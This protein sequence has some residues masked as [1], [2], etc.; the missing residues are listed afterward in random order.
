MEPLMQDHSK[1]NQ[2]R[3]PTTNSARR[4]RVATTTALLLM[5]ALHASSDA[6]AQ[7]K[8]ESAEQAAN[9]LMGA[10]GNNDPTNMLAILGPQYEKQLVTPD[11]DAEAEMRQKIA[12]AAEKKQVLQPISDDT[13]EV[14]IGAEEWPLPIPLIR[15]DEGTWSFETEEGIEVIIDRRIGRNEKSAVAVM[16]AYVDAQIEYAQVDRNGDDYFEYAQRLASS[17]GQQDGLYW[18]A[19]E[20]SD[21]SPFGP[22]VQGAERYLGTVAAGDP[23]R[24]Y[25]FKV[26]T[27]QGANAPGGEQS[28]VI[29]GRMVL[30]FALVA[31]PADFG[32]SGVMTFV[33]NHRGIVQ[34]KDIGAFDG[35]DTYD[36][37]DTWLEVEAGS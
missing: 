33:V 29:D 19:S 1:S 12:V 35:M 36:P 28:Y 31:F 5:A 7:Q 16:N 27:R 32:N 17:P 6:A 9:A 13:I 21:E 22:L 34:Q 30:G 2:F 14:V 25:R 3:M 11:W 18:E 10:I 15:D 24:G 8:F 4:R 20:G 26:L 23:I 37:D